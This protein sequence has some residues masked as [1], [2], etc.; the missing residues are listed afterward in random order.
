MKRASD[1]LGGKP[2]STQS[3]IATITERRR[4]SVYLQGTA[5]SSCFRS[6]CK[7]EERVYCCCFAATGK[8]IGLA[9]PGLLTGRGEV[10]LYWG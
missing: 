10:K 9:G 1:T 7:V 4:K 5:R 3:C 8:I 2:W 6:C